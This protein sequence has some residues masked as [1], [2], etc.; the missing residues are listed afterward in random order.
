M[1]IKNE[2]LKLDIQY[3]AQSDAEVKF[4][5]TL[6]DN[7]AN[8]QLNDLSNKGSKVTSAFEKI[9]SVGKTVF[10]GLA[11]G[12]GTATTAISGLVAKSVQM[13]GELEQNIGGAGAVFGEL[14]K[15]ISEIG[16]TFTDFD[17]TTGEFIDNYWTLEEVSKNAFK[18][19]G[20]SANDYLATINKMGSLMQGAGIDT[21]TSLYLSAQAMQR[22]SDVASIMGIDISSAME[23]IAGAAK[24]N[25]TMMDNL[26]VA[27]N[28]TTI[29]AYA[30]SKGINRSYD[31]MDNATKIGLAMEMFLEKTAYAAGNYAKEN[32]T[33]AGSFNTLKAATS[34][35]LSGAGGIEE[36]S[37]ALIDFGEILIESIGK[38]A[39][40]VVEGLTSLT[41]TLIPQIP[42][43]IQALLPSVLDGAMSLINS[44]VVI[45]PA[46]ITMI[47]QNLP[48]I[49]QGGMKI[50][51]TLLNTILSM[52]PDI[53]KMGITLILELAKGITQQLPELIPIAIDTILTL[54]DTLLD[55]IEQLVDAGIILILAL[56][57]GLIEALPTLID[58]A[59]IIID[60]LITAFTE[61]L[62]KLIQAGITLI[63]KLAEGLIKAI[64]Q[65]ISKIPQIISSLINGI[66]SYYGNLLKIGGELLNKVKEGITSGISSMA[67][68]GKNLVQGLWNGINNAK[69]W[70]LGKIK[71]FGSSIVNGI[72]GIFGIHSP[73]KVMFEIGGYL[74]E[75]F[76]DGIKDMEKDIDKQIDSTFGSGLDYLYSG[77]DNFSAG[78]PDS[79]YASIPMQTIYLSNE[80]SNSSIL[81]VDGRVLAETVNT[82][83]NEREVAV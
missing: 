63:V 62:P 6:D 45:F 19:M 10:K 81:Q 68:I 51:A 80:N 44:L 2:K 29:E 48:T 22:A 75:G 50:V 17:H 9:G 78:L 3:F 53:L 65:L 25:F 59:P 36:V 32:R 12:V 4:K 33:F 56:A 15:S 14:G 72:K 70:V 73:S 67:D 26:G 28:A 11:I 35:F 16:T 42:I 5:V 31:S 23:S 64:P 49:V 43:L 74:D 34:N 82:Y 47:E 54:V 46:L 38:M 1:K 77:Y 27:M 57:D 60:K 83:N 21:E 7:N 61:N 37:T 58:K 18:N 41:E 30:L 79:T 8:N 66:A 40:S 71:G 24:G 20:V 55:N 52:L 69:D 76:I 13:A 39:P